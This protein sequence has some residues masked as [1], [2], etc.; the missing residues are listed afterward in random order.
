MNSFYSLTPIHPQAH[1][2]VHI[3]LLKLNNKTN[4]NQIIAVSRERREASWVL[5]YLFKL[6]NGFFLVHNLYDFGR[7]PLTFN[8]TFLL[9]SLL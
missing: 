3:N 6:L 8:Y 1:K 5:L 4:W 9:G 2:N 7:P